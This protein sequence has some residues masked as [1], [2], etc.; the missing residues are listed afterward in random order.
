MGERERCRGRREREGGERRE[1][2]RVGEG[3][4]EGEGKTRTYTMKYML[5][6][7][8]MLSAPSHTF[9]YTKVCLIAL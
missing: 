4:R 9:L 7:E 6:F 5:S 1:E 2:G 3:R 8:L